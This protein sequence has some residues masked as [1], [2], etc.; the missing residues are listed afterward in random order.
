MANE[1]NYVDFDFD[2]I[3]TQLQDH[4]RN[5]A[6]WKDVYRSSTGQT[7]I[8][9]LGYVLNLAMFYAERRAEES[10]LSTAQLR[11]SIVN[12]VSLLNYQPKRK[13]SSSGSLTFSIDEALTKIVYIPKYTECQSV[14]G[15]KFITNAPAAIQKGQ[16]SV[17]VAAIQGE[18]IQTEISPD[19]SPDQKYTINS[20]N[21]ENSIDTTN[22]TLRVLIDGEL[23]T[24]VSSFLGYDSSSK[25]YR[26]LNNM[27]GTVSVLFG[28]DSAGMAP[29][30]GTTLVIQYV[31]SAG[32]SGN[33]TST[34]R[35]TTINDSIYDEDGSVVTVS[36]TNSGT[37]L[38]GDDEESIEEIRKEAPLVFKTGDRAVTKEDFVA[39]ISNFSG[40]AD[41]NVW[42][43]NEEAELAGTSAVQSML[44]KVKI[45]LILQEWILPDDDFK[46]T[47]AA[48]VYDKSML[49][50]KY[51]FVDPV[52]LN[53][54]PL[55]IVK[56]NQGYS[57]SQTQADIEEEL[58]AQFLLGDTAKLG[59]IVKYSSILAALHDL[60]SVAYVNMILEIYHELSSTYSSTY[61]WGE[62]LDALPIRPESTR[63]FID[64]TYVTT[65]VD[66]GDGTGTF[67]SAGSY[68]ISGTID[69]ETGE[70]LLDISPA[71]S[72]VYVRYQQQPSDDYEQNR[73]IEPALRQIGKLYTTDI[74]SIT[75]VS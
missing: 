42:G 56:V 70:I 64:D 38:G 18:I 17:S 40:V 69:Y 60:D 26:I 22:P 11:S 14:D 48:D 19:G 57:L 4:L 27:E 44:N 74:Q 50:V 30:S 1:L 2:S 8:E 20:Q 15:I 33:V 37:F 24:P 61:D 35:I 16:T 63:L 62:E 67:S 31:E 34:D 12:L 65:D 10:Y 39:I 68:T 23:W 3:V 66:N 72:T 59:T 25:V 41:V 46:T 45:C 75:V 13:T 52:I 9:L 28:D 36:V 53:I 21:V 6:A 47:V 73:N 58:A 55:L 43:E 32:L 71:A 51:E 5:T 49:T 7:L 29:E 54:I